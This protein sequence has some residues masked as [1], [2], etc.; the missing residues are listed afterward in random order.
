MQ[1]LARRLVAC[2]DWEWRAGMGLLDGRVIVAVGLN[3]AFQA[4][5]GLLLVTRLEA[6]PPIT[7][8]LGEGR[9]LPDPRDERVLD[10][11]TAMVSATHQDCQLHRRL[12]PPGPDGVEW[13]VILSRPGTRAMVCRGLLLADALFQALLSTGPSG[14]D[15]VS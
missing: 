10:V 7:E 1:R 12:G 3:T 14:D 2:P 15:G 8:T 9:A 11:L 13:Q 4:A 5:P 6:R